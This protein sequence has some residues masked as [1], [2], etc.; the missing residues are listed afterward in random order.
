MLVLTS[1]TGLTWAVPPADVADRLSVSLTLVLTAVAYK[2]TVPQSIPQ[3][4]Y[5][6][7]LDK[8]VSLCFVFMVLV[9]VENSLVGGYDPGDWTIGSTDTILCI[10]WWV[11]W[12]LTCVWYAMPVRRLWFKRRYAVEQYTQHQQEEGS[13]RRTPEDPSSNKVAPFESA[14][15]S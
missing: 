3:V 15:K 12:L 5:L 7:L 4:A 8:F 9:A 13:A 2:L 6:T 1:L 10:L 11:L 14:S